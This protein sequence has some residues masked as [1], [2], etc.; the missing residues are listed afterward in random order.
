MPPKPP[1]LLVAISA[2]GFGHVAQ[3]SI[4]LSALRRM[5]PDMRLTVQSG[6]ERSR[7]ALKG[8]EPFDRNA[9]DHDFGF[10]ME[11]S[12]RTV[13]LEASIAAY[14]RIGTQCDALVAEQA[15]SLTDR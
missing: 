3:T 12:A 15:Q 14:R 2:N 4:V 1:H 11:R 6:L 7:I 13:D 9:V 8:D 5:V 10:I